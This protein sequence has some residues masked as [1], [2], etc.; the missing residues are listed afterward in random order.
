MN[1]VKKFWKPLEKK[2]SAL[3]EQQT[4]S[5][6]RAKKMNVTEAP[7]GTTLGVAEAFGPT[8]QIPYSSALS[9][10]TVGAGVWCVWTAGD[11]STLVAMWPGSLV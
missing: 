3:V 10:V 6:I 7:N 5:C 2:I 9:S 4:K 1:D 11:A 8:I